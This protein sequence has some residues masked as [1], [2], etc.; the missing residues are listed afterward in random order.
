MSDTIDQAF[1]TEFQDDVHLAYQQ[2]GSKIRNTCRLKTNVKAE[3][4]RFQVYGSGVAGQKSRNGDVPVMNNVHSYKDATM[5][6]WYGAD[7]VDKLDELKVNI[8]ER[9][10]AARSGA[11]A[12]GR[13][14][15]TICVAALRLSLPAA[16]K[17]AH[18]SAGLTKAKV[19]S[20]LEI[21]NGDDGPP[22]D[23]E[24][25]ALVGPHQWNELLNI[26]EFKDADYTGDLLPWTKGTEAKRWLNS[27]WILSNRLVLSGGY[28]Y[29]L[30]YH[31]SAL[32]LGE[33]SEII[34]T[35][36]WVAHKASY[37]V[38]SM[39]SAG[40]IRIDDGGVVEI[41]CDDDASIS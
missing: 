17:V 36:D 10:A 20:A 16:Q 30:W 26:S 5:A 34:T 18:G 11:G 24:R 35:I 8:D 29:C 37:L 14:I 32:G 33:N 21:L 31:R 9:Q 12:L 25:Y 22:D 27:T 3:T 40:A 2:F 1:L 19:L 4:C 41:A 13:R 15:D 38:D 28:R 39:M 7:Y 6:D 23:G